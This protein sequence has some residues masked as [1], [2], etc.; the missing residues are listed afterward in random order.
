MAGVREKI[1]FNKKEKCTTTEG[2]KR[3]RKWISARRKMVAR[4][5]CVSKNE[6]L[7]KNVQIEETIRKIEI[8]KLRDAK[9]F[10]KS[11]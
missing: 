10:D 8:A 3:K 7:C 11:V 2:R 4:K 9:R 6:V 5:V 1:N